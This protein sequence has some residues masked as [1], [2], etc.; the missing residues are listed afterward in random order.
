MGGVSKRWM[1]TI[2][3]ILL[4]LSIILVIDRLAEIQSRKDIILIQ[5]LTQK[6]LD[7]TNIYAH[8]KVGMFRYGA[9]CTVSYL[10]A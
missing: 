8:T 7:H 4:L 2:V 9:K 6:Q 10:C 5:K 1:F 3:A